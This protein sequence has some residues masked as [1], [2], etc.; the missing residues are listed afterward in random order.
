[1]LLERAGEDRHE[2]RRGGHAAR[3]GVTS[4]RTRADSH[5]NRAPSRPSCARRP[6]RCRQP[7]DAVLEHRPRRARVGRGEERKHVHVGVPEHVPAVGA[8][9]SARA[10]RPR[11]RRRSGALA[12]RWKSAN[13]TASCSSGSPSIT[14]VS[15]LPPRRPRPAVLAEQTVESEPACALGRGRARRCDRR[16]RERRPRSRRRDRAPGPKRC[17]A[18]C[19]CAAAAIDPGPP[20]HP[21]PGAAVGLALLVSRLRAAAGASRARRMLRLRPVTLSTAVPGHASDDSSSASSRLF[22]RSELLAQHPGMKVE[23]AADRSWRGGARAR[24]CSIAARPAGASRRPPLCRRRTSA[25][26]GRRSAARA[27]TLPRVPSRPSAS[28]SSDSCTRSSSGST[29]SI[30]KRPL[31]VLDDDR[32]LAA[33]AACEL[34]LEHSRERFRSAAEPDH[35]G[36]NAAGLDADRYRRRALAVADQQPESLPGRPPSGPSSSPAINTWFWRDPAP[37][38]PVA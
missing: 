27:I 6:H 3:R 33:P 1:M 24:S 10:P 8:C 9:R 5:G 17:R 13:R 37:P 25:P 23:H 19:S 11:P 28:V 18:D 21:H 7:P 20:R 15:V 16:S 34:V 12:S 29:P 2:L 26:L 35:A 31:R 38:Q 4:R 30:D 36:R 14:H 22:S 32:Q